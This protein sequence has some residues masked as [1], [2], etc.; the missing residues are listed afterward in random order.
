MN[1]ALAKAVQQAR[2]NEWNV[3]LRSVALH[4]A[5]KD[6]SS[7]RTAQCCDNDV[8]WTVP[9]ELVSAQQ[10]A[11]HDDHHVHQAVSIEAVSEP[12]GLVG[13]LRQ[14][15]ERRAPGGGLAHGHGQLQE[16]FTDL[17]AANAEVARLR[18]EVMQLKQEA[19]SVQ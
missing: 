1:P 6:T 8:P 17:P 12:H 5:H 3:A 13:T 4:A 18:Q 16:P 19:A 14:H 7:R 11:Q 10:S 15:A 9:T 2:S